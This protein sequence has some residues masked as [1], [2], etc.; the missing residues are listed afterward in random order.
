MIQ[1]RLVGL[2]ECEY[3]RLSGIV[4]EHTDNPYPMKTYNC[5][6]ESNS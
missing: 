4:V 3:F 6:I 5:K 2:T 1:F